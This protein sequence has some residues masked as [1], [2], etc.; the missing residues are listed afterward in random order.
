MVIAIN[1]QTEKVRNMLSG[2]VRTIPEAT[3]RGVY[4]LA[5]FGA[6]ALKDEA[7]RAG[8][9]HWGGGKRQLLSNQTRARKLSKGN[10]V[11]VMPIHG[12]YLDSMQPHFVALKRGR[13]ITKWAKEKGI[14]ASAIF[15][16][17]HPFIRPA[18][19]RTISKAKKIVEKEVNRAVKAKGK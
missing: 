9:K 8:I 3:N 10:Y 17:P 2:Y 15:V 14:K 5:R 19:R 12:K 13:L 7:R 16:K 18:V 1:I 4:N 6:K 11:V